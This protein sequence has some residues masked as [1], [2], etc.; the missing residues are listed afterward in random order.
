MGL[1]HK[2]SYSGN[3]I[4]LI[5]R[6]GLVVVFFWGVSTAVAWTDRDEVRYNRYPCH[7]RLIYDQHLP[8][9]VAFIGSSR[10]VQGVDAEIVS[11]SLGDNVS[12]IN[13]AKSWRGQG[14]NFTILRDL[15]ENRSVRLLMVEANLPETGIF[16]GH[17]F[18]VGRISDWWMSNRFR[19]DTYFDPQ[20]LLVTLRNLVDRV[21]E[22]W[23]YA[24]LNSEVDLANAQNAD[25]GIPVT[26]CR[27]RE[28]R[29]RNED[30]WAEKISRY[31]EYYENQYFS[32]DLDSVSARHDTGFYRALVELASTH[33]TDI[34]FYHVP[35]AYNLALDPAFSSVF[36]EEIGAPLIIPPSSL[37]RDMEDLEVFADVTHLMPR[38]REIYSRWLSQA[39]VNATKRLDDR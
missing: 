17:F 38:G 2:F 10:S 26:H 11:S 21:T 33:D 25:V 12:A 19:S 18:L 6:Y 24:V 16:H 31:Q 29:R 8:I 9:D 34:V 1:M 23:T 32:W 5:I 28:E 13:L 4:C 14:I 35:E 3:S 20:A 37:T 27:V 39:V 30:Y 15:L 36:E 7:Y 22:Q